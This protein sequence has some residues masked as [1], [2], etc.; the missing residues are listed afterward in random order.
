MK[1][2]LS[3][4][5]AFI[6]L[7]SLCIVSA[8]ALTEY[9]DIPLAVGG[10]AN[11]ITVLN[12]ND[13]HSY[14][15]VLVSQEMAESFLPYSSMLPDGFADYT[16]IP[17]AAIMGESQTFNSYFVDTETTAP[18]VFNTTYTLC[19][20]RID[21]AGKIIGFTKAEVKTIEDE[22]VPDNTMRLGDSNEDNE[23]NIKDATLIQKFIAETET[24]SEFQQVLADVNEDTKVNV[25]DATVIQKYTAGIDTGCEIGKKISYLPYV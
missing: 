3:I 1:K 13:G 14:V 7:C 18:L 9:D 21:E 8:S 24:L 25:K 22:E 2:T 16:L 5:L 4:I 19:L 20:F 6:M 10:D 17:G 23:I 15:A 11:S 12:P